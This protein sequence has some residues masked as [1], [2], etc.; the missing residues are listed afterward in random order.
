M[1]TPLLPQGASS[2]KWSRDKLRIAAFIGLGL[3]AACVLAG[4]TLSVDSN[5]HLCCAVNTDHES[6]EPK[7]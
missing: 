1:G 7:L 2:G 4:I 3:L 6:N 5:G